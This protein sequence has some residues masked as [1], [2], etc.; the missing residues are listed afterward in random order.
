MPKPSAAATLRDVADLHDQISDRLRDFA[1]TLDD[2]VIPPPT[3]VAAR[4]PRVSD[5]EPATEVED[6]PEPTRWNLTHFPPDSL[7]GHAERALVEAG[8]PLSLDDW[9][10]RI[11]SQ[12]FVHD[13][14][15]R[16]PRQLEASLSA[17]P[18]Q[19]SV[20]VRVSRRVYDLAER[21]SVES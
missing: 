19:T 20:F 14:N 5:H 15:P 2:E 16:N 10:D 4:P 1:A 17:L 9:A 8:R 12:G 21:S 6:T 18:H 7:R 11:R 13:W 3:A